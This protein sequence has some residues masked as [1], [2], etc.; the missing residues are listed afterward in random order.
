[1]PVTNEK[2]EKL[3]KLLVRSDLPVQKKCHLNVNINRVIWVKEKFDIRNANHP[4]RAEIM[5][6]IEDIL[7]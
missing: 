4:K 5:A 6:L 7:S 1:M 3:E 2:L